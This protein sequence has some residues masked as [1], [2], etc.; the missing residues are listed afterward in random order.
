MKPYICNEGQT[1]S[2]IFASIVAQ[3]LMLQIKK[4]KVQIPNL[5]KYSQ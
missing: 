4:C 3:W 1:C 5:N 2:V